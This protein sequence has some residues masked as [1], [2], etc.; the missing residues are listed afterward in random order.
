[1]PQIHGKECQK[2]FGG[3]TTEACVI[4]PQWFG[5]GAT[6]LL[7]ASDFVVSLLLICEDIRFF[8]F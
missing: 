6:F 3:E 2:H 7:S 5:A 4:A 8:T 1:M